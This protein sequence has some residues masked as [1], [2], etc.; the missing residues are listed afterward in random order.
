MIGQLTYIAAQAQLE[1]RLRSARS[2]RQA[3]SV[4]AQ[5]RGIATV[6]VPEPRPRRFHLRRPQIAA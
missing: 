6:V 4:N 1:S 3:A 2:Q 5:K